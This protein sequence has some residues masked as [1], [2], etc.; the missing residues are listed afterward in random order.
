MST[1]PDGSAWMEPN[2]SY[3]CPTPYNVLEESTSAIVA[4]QGA[5]HKLAV[6]DSNKAQARVS[7]E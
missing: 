6:I 4:S 7:V 1:K 3:F 2:R 5:A